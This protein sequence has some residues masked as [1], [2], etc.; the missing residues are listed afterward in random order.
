M[1]RRRGERGAVTAELAMGLPLLLALTVGL[2]WLVGVGSAQVRAVDAAREAA[3]ALARGDSE[4]A[5]VGVAAAVAPGGSEI[6]VST[7][8]GRVVV[9]VRAT[10]RGPGGLFDALP[11]AEVSA[12]AVALAE[13]SP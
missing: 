8:D 13:E 10:V 1:T 12:E 3:R 4:S 5:A 7:G 2:A 6:S 11:G 9:R